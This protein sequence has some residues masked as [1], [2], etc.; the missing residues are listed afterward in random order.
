[1]TSLRLRDIKKVNESLVRPGGRNFE[2][3]DDAMAAIYRDKYPFERL[4]IA[5][6]LWSLARSLLVNSLRSLHPDWEEKKI[7]DE[8]VRRTSHGTS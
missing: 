6:G 4:H 8:A 3:I 1:L 5:F 7:H 2:N